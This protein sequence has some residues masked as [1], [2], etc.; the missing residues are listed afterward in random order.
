MLSKYNFIP[1]CCVITKPIPFY[2]LWNLTWPFTVCESK[3]KI[4]S[5]LALGRTYNAFFWVLAFCYFYHFIIYEYG[6]QPT[7]RVNF[8]KSFITYIVATFKKRTWRHNWRFASSNILLGK[9]SDTNY[10]S[11]PHY[12]LLEV[13]PY[14]FKLLLIISFPW[15]LHK[16]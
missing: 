12:Q 16:V 11:Q 4:T 9:L 3:A 15:Q 1:I 14:T 7:I 10:A 2:L 8:C 13:S 6:R 5:Q